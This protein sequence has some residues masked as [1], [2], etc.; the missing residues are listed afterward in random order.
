MFV[1]H[2]CDSH[3]NEERM[4]LLRVIGRCAPCSILRHMWLVVQE[5]QTCIPQRNM[6]WFFA[7]EGHRSGTLEVVSYSVLLLG[8]VGSS[9]NVLDILV[10]NLTLLWLL[11]ITTNTLFWWNCQADILW[12]H[13]QMSAVLEGTRIRI[14]CSCFA[15]KHISYPFNIHTISVAS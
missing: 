4:G 1:F 3:I 11:Y 6:I 15:F 13:Q 9:V 5:S 10:S 2:V 7:G 14:G 12:T 8:S